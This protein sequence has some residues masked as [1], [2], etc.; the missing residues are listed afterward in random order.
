MSGLEKIID[1]LNEENDAQ[2]AEILA[3]ASEKAEAIIRNAQE[4]GNK[5]IGDAAEEAR[6]KADAIRSRAVSQGTMNERRQMLETRVGMIE[7][8]LAEARQRLHE[9]PDDQYFE[10]L[11]TLIDRQ[12]RPGKGVLLLSARDLRRA[13]QAFVAKLGDDIALS[14]SP[15]EIEDG[16]IL[17]YGDIELNN[18]F[19][20][21]FLAA[22]EDLRAK[23]G[24]LLFD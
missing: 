15:A 22:D 3:Q 4:D 18:S 11:L 19:R 23:A 8:V 12:R 2:C 16:F 13:P 7:E 1:R 5:L 14:P 24:A 20:A 10:T 17:K 6:R 21:L 9:L